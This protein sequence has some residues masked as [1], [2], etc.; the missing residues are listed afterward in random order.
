MSGRECLLDEIMRRVLALRREELPPECC[1]QASARRVALA[2]LLRPLASNAAGRSAARR[3]ML[4]PSLIVFLRRYCAKGRLA[5]LYLKV[6]PACCCTRAR[7][8]LEPFDACEAFDHEHTM[9]PLLA[10]HRSRTEK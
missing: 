6:L 4:L 2:S 9:Q 1:L 10:H 3:L 7:A 8:A 5:S